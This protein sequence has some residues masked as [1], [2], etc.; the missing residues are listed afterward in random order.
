MRRRS[1]LIA[2]AAV[3]ATPA[4]FAQGDPLPSWN[5]APRAALLAFVQKVT[6]PGG[7]DFV[8]VPERIAVFDND[9]T[10]WSEQPTYFQ[11]AFAFERVKAL[12]PQHPDWNE[13]EPFKS[14]LAGD[15]KGLAARRLSCQLE[16]VA[17]RRDDDG[18]RG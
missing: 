1:L 11:A 6:T 2:A 14:V 4:A 15:M 13:R 3:A 10:L 7:P 18:H 12:A 16:I 9:G 17:M 8:P 5:G